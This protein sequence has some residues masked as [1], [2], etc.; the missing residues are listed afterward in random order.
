MPVPGFRGQHLEVD[1][2]EA[3]D[4]AQAPLGQ[5]G[6]VLQTGLRAIA[7]EFGLF[8]EQTR[9]GA[10]QD[11]AFQEMFALVDAAES[12]G[13]DVFWLA[14]MLVNPARTVLSPPLAVASWLA[15]RT[16][17]LRVRAADHLLPVAYPF[18]LPRAV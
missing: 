15:S 9:R 11:D 6:P 16:K 8:A 10:N 2:P 7:M 1:E 14:E 18:R 12:W 17:R 13:L 4:T 5:R 3:P